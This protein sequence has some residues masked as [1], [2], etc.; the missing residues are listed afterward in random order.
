MRLYLVLED[1]PQRYLA[2]AWTMGEVELSEYQALVSKVFAIRESNTARV[3]VKY[4]SHDPSVRILVADEDDPESRRCLIS[5]SQSR[6]QDYGREFQSKGFS[7]ERREMVEAIRD[8]VRVYDAS[9]ATGEVDHHHAKAEFT[10]LLQ[11]AALH[12]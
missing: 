5:F 9:L 3:V 12:Q 2:R 4:L 11:T 7:S 6:P 10:T 8:L 1:G